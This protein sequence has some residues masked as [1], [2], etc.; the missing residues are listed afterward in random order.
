[1]TFCDPTAE[2]GVSFRKDGQRTDGGGSRNCYLDDHC[3]FILSFYLI[4]EKLSPLAVCQ[5]KL[6]FQKIISNFYNFDQFPLI[7]RQERLVF[8]GVVWDVE[9]GLKLIDP[10]KVYN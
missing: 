6:V 10:L 8:L 7:V 9:W 4:F 5:G 3:V 2:T 1:M